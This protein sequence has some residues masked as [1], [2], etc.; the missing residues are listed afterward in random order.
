MLS[1][2]GEMDHGYV[3]LTKV[4]PKISDWLMS[5]QDNPMVKYDIYNVERSKDQ[6][7]RRL[8]STS[9][10]DWIMREYIDLGGDKQ[11]D[12]GCI[13]LAF[14]IQFSGINYKTFTIRAF[15][16]LGGNTE[17]DKRRFIAGSQ[18][19]YLSPYYTCQ[20]Y[21]EEDKTT[22]IGFC[23]A[24][25]A[26]ITAAML[27]GRTVSKNNT[28]NTGFVA[29]NCYDV[30]GALTYD[31]E[32]GGDLQLVPTPEWAAYDLHTKGKL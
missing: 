20:A 17:I 12:I 26:N 19:R 24:P 4:W 18:G 7:F 27:A 3:F 30:E 31:A 15:T 28:D 23:F 2:I 11:E 6:N 13:S 22:L 5:S 10:I 25:T 8:D 14:R 21:M 29:V 16:K 9:N 1:N 32:A